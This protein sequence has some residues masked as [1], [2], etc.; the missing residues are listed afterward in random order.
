VV[1]IFGSTDPHAT[2]PF[3]EKV[4]VIYHALPCSPCLKRT[5]DLGY[6]C[7]TDISVQEVFEAA[8]GWVH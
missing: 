4:T 5:C 7:L 1:A 6:P 8:K 2:S 3:T